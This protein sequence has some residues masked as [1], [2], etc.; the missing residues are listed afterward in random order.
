MKCIL[1]KKIINEYILH[2]NTTYVTNEKDKRKYKVR[3]LYIYNTN[4]STKFNIVGNDR[5]LFHTYTLDNFM[6]HNSKLKID[7]LS[8]IFD[9]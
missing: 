6:K 8:T 1:M 3:F 7:Q 5:S 9:L 2:Q 4:C